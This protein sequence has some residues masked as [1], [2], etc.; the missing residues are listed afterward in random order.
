M[1]VRPETGAV[2]PSAGTV[3]ISFESGT[4]LAQALKD[5]ES[6]PCGRLPG[7]QIRNLAVEGPVGFEPTA[8]GLKV[9]PGLFSPVISNTALT[10]SYLN[11]IT[12]SRPIPPDHP[13]F[14]RDER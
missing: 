5:V 8:P 12:P 13:S 2:T 6:H 4:R 9:C 7:F 10:V 3:V 11:S 1:S 14:R